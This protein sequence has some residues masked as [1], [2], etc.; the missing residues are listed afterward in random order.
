MSDTHG[1]AIDLDEAIREHAAGASWRVLSERLGVSSSTLTSR[2][3]QHRIARKA[4]L[5]LPRSPWRSDP[6][7]HLGKGIPAIMLPA[8]VAENARVLDEHM[9]AW[10]QAQPR[11][12]PAPA[13]AKA[14]RLVHG[15]RADG[16]RSILMAQAA[17]RLGIGLPNLGELLA[18]HARWLDD[19][20]ATLGRP[21][22][23]R[24]RVYPV[25]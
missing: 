14:W 23:K 20:D 12:P 19:A 24:H 18:A 1:P 21:S 13:A 17:R 3:H 25:A 15:V 11:P 5:G 4:E 10:R 2:V 22:V 9:A 16:R 6:A 8:L 7:E